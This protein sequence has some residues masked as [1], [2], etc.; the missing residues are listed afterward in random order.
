[1]LNRNL[2]LCVPGTTVRKVD[3]YGNKLL[4]WNV[5]DNPST[6]LCKKIGKNYFDIFSGLK[7]KNFN[8]TK[9]DG[10]MSVAYIL[11]FPSRKKLIS[12][13]KLKEILSEN[14]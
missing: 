2:F 4:F 3:D 9:G 12:S 14:N 5:N 13:K 8:E 6:I 11:P 1:M 10:V 7:Y